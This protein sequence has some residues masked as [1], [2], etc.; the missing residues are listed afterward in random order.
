ME[1]VVAYFMLLLWCLPEGT[2]GITKDVSHCGRCPYYALN[3]TTPT[4][5]A[6]TQR[7]KKKAEI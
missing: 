4:P 6:D 5:H 7:R 2:H 3:Y 1:V